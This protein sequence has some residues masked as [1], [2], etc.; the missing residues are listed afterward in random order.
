MSSIDR[1]KNSSTREPLLDIVRIVACLI[2]VMHHAAFV[3]PWGEEEVA[4]SPV[5]SMLRTA[6]LNVLKFGTGTPI[7]FALAGFLVMGT[8]ER[9]AGRREKVLQSLWRRFRRIMPPYWLAIGLTAL[10][11]MTLERLGLQS[12][13]GGGYALE[14]VSPWKL[15]KMQWLG[16]LTLIETWRPL[17]ST[18]PEEIFTRVAWT[19]CYH[20]QF[21]FVAM[22]IGILAGSRWR[23]SLIGFAFALTAV[24]VFLFDIGAS[25]R[26]KGLF[27]DRWYLFGCGLIAW[28]ISRRPNCDKL[29]WML[30]IYL[31]AGMAAGVRV[32][33]LEI[34][35]AS[36]SAIVLAFGSSSLSARV[37]QA[38][39]KRWASLT[40]WTYP[41][42]LIHLPAETIFIRF[43]TEITLPGF[44]V[45]A[46]IVVPLTMVI[47]VA[48]GIAFGKLVN[49]LDSV[50][51]EKSHVSAASQWI[52][53][54][55]GLSRQRT[56]PAAKA[57]PIVRMVR[58]DEF[59]RPAR[60]GNP[61]LKP[62]TQGRRL[63]DRTPWPNATQ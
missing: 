32:N 1:T 21:I 14:F 42:F 33:D 48:A 27:L 36:I 34:T 53:E 51:I 49:F 43:L 38:T 31:A 57:L 7:F 25:F 16:N 40:P 17:I 4:G 15:S 46:L 23:G 8:L 44:W 61:G 58:T 2:V 11:L 26:A 9:T 3:L 20:E 52:I 10:L 47:G 63:S 45:R 19:L 29:K 37:S 22:L 18:D 24:Q 5:W 35:I 62:S 12:L 30:S 41:I 6:V 13:F 28:E 55:S 59:P 50:T 56:W 54:R 60:D 39:A